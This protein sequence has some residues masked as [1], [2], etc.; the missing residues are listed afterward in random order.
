MGCLLEFFLVDGVDYCYVWEFI[1]GLDDF[2]F[3]RLNVILLEMI[4]YMVYVVILEGELIVEEVLVEV[5]LLNLQFLLIFVIF[6]L[7]DLI[8]IYLDEG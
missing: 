4:I 1:D 2:V 6:C 5:I 7:N 8:I 3:V